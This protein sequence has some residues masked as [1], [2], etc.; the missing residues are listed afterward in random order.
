MMNSLPEAIIIQKEQQIVYTNRSVS[1]LLEINNNEEMKNQPEETKRNP[2]NDIDSSPSLTTN[3]CSSISDKLKT[4]K[5]DT[6]NLY[7]FLVKEDEGPREMSFQFMSKNNEEKRLHTKVLS[8]Q[9][10]GKDC[11]M[12]KIEDMTLSMQ[13]ERESLLKKYQNIFLSSFSHELVT[14]LNGILGLLELMENENPPLEIAKYI[15]TAKSNGMILFYLITDIVEMYKG[16]NNGKMIRRNEWI[17]PFKI[18][19]ECQKLLEFAFN[20]RD[21]V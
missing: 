7:D 5:H 1:T 21:I 14:P 9:F 2:M 15:E 12:C 18:I 3:N 13:L 19:E 16:E 17:E 11:N 4:I 10:E 20:Q 8:I 6:T